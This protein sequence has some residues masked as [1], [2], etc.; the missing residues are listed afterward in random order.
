MSYFRA[1]SRLLKG[2]LIFLL[3][4]LSTLVSIGNYSA[5][6]TSLSDGPCNPTT[7]LGTYIGTCN[8]VSPGKYSQKLGDD[9][10]NFASVKLSYPT[11]AIL[12]NS[13][14]D[15]LFNVT[16]NPLMFNPLSAQVGSLVNVWGTGFSSSDTTCSISGNPVSASACTISGGTLT[17]SFTVANVLAGKYTITGT[18]IQNGDFSSNTFTVLPPSLI[19]NPSSGPTGTTV[20]VSGFGFYT[21]DLTCTLIGGP[22]PPIPCAIAPHPPAPGGTIGI[23][24]LLSFV[25]PPASATGVYSITVTTNGG[26]TGEASASFTVTPLGSPSITLSPSSG[27]GPPPPLTVSVSGS[28]FSVTD[29]TCSLSGNPVSTPTSCA[30]VGGTIAVGLSFTVANVQA[31]VYTIT[32]TGSPGGDSATA[33][34]QVLPSAPTTPIYAVVSIDIYVPPDFTGLTLSQIWTSFTNDYDQ[35]VI[36]LRRQSGADQIGPNWWKISLSNL[37]VTNSPSLY[38]PARSR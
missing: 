31:G 24:P 14:G 13:T 27:L 21:T 23:A 9:F 32:V 7:Y 11:G 1:A 33:S 25:V 35:N 34:F 29:T 5:H 12:T 18:G 37:T 17:G 20:D 3:L 28:G 4:I 16:L 15:L 26:D 10:P 19:L 2:T 22:V 36:S 38:S 30:I 6:S 8:D